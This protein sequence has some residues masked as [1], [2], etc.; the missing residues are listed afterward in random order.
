MPSASPAPQITHLATLEPSS[1]SRAWLTAPHPPLPL[2]PTCPPHKTV[3]I[4]PLT[5]FTLLST[6]SGGHKRS[7]RTCAWK[8]NLKGESVLATG[9]F[10]A[11]VGIWRHYDNDMTPKPK[12]V[13]TGLDFDARDKAI[14]SGDLGENAEEEDDEEWRFVV[15]LDGHTSE[16]KSVAW[17]TGGNLLATCSRDNTFAGLISLSLSK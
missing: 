7:I 9:S 8:P 12:D 16:V 1:P 13:M 4:Y 15:V 11:S 6:I 2:L 17:S 3:R 14:A 10:D 5:T